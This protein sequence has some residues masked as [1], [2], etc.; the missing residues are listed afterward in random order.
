MNEPPNDYKW[1]AV[2]GSGQSRPWTPDTPTF[3]TTG[4]STMDYVPMESERVRHVE[5]HK[6]WRW[7]HRGYEKKNKD[8]HASREFVPPYMIRVE[9]EQPSGSTL[10]ITTMQV[11][12]RPGVCRTFFKS[13]LSQRPPRVQ[14]QQLLQGQAKAAQDASAQAAGASGSVKEPTG[15][16]VKWAKGADAA[17]PGLGGGIFSLLAR[18]PHW[19]PFDYLTSDQDVVMMCRQELLMRRQGLNRRSYFL[20]SPSDEGIAA[21]NRWL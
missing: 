20:N 9:Y 4:Y 17:P 1:V 8:M 2:S 11:P 13:G 7:E 12:V 21:I 15:A 6:G 10:Y 16:A 14:Q 19:I 5:L 3:C 18:V